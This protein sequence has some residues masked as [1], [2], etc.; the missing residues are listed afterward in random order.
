MLTPLFGRNFRSSFSNGL[1]AKTPRSRIVGLSTLTTS[2]VFRPL[3][4]PDSTDAIS[5]VDGEYS[6]YSDGAWGA[7]TSDAG[8]WGS[9]TRVQIKLT[10]SGIYSTSISAVLTVGVD[11]YEFEV[12]TV[13][14]TYSLQYLF[15]GDNQLKINDEPLHAMVLEAV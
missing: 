8:T 5:I 12:L 9:A 6:L 2:R 3:P 4:I 15:S 10:S 11:E 14:A 7:F 1:L 13:D